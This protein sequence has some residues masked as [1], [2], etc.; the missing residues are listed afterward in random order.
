MRFQVYTVRIAWQNIKYK[1]AAT[2]TSELNGREFNSKHY[3]Y[4]IWLFWIRASFI[5]LTEFFFHIFCVFS[6]IVCL[7]LVFEWRMHRIIY[8]LDI[9]LITIENIY[10]FSFT[11]NTK[12]TT[13]NKLC[14][15]RDYYYYGWLV[16][17]VRLVFNVA[18]AHAPILN[19]V[20]R[21]TIY[22]I[23]N[24]NE[25]KTKPVFKPNVRYNILYPYHI[26][27]ML[28]FEFCAS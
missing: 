11:V 9:G 13:K 8:V 12:Y 4:Y 20:R 25:R 15:N 1:T 28:F 24:E 6:V 3:Y 7:L 19:R 16:S 5:C 22:V 17:L 26:T 2:L 27:I 14:Y 21:C 10:A 18:M 23:D